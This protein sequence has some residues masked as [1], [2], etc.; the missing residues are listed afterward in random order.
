M[1]RLTA[2]KVGAWKASE[3]RQQIPDDLCVGLY[4]MVQPTGRKS[5]SVR[6][7]VGSAH[8]RYMVGKFPQIGLAE[9]RDRAREVLKAAQGGKD[10][11]AEKRQAKVDTVRAIVDEFDRF[12]LSKLKSRK[13]AMGFL[14]RSIVA[15]W[16]DRPLRDISKRDVSR[17]VLAIV[18]SGREVT[19]N[20]TLAHVRKFFNWCAENGYID[21]PP[22]DRMKMPA[23]EQ[24]RDRFLAA[25]EIKWF[26]QACS[27]QAQPWGHMGKMLLLTGCRLSEVAGMNDAEISGDV[28]EIPGSRTKNGHAHKVPLSSLASDVLNGVCRI[29]SSGYIFTTNGAT[30]VS[31]FHK[32]RQHI[33]DE[34]QDLA[35]AHQIPHWTFHDLRR[36]LE[37]ELA[38]M[39]VA[40]TLIDRITNH[41]SAIPKMRR[42]YQQYDYLQ[43]RREALESWA[44]HVKGLNSA[45]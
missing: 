42:V 27:N 26:W 25:Q 40:E 14:Q 8:R 18:E 2:A 20:R 22:T 4:L 37:T 5:W 10:P 34:M 29:G 12:H 23:V 36:T 15:E 16:G 28:W 9:A 44:N 45:L 24:S 33:A 32:G 31:G 1:A 3:E 35:G 6:Y 7:R 19:A 21:H 41:L 17:L 11:S 13:N 38:R 30:P 43:E 39:G